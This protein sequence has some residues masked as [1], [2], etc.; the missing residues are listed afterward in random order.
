MSDF[1]A[2]VAND[3]DYSGDVLGNHGLGEH[4]EIGELL[5]EMAQS[6]GL[7]VGGTSIKVYKSTPGHHLIEA[8]NTDRQ[9]S[10]E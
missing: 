10:Y 5:L 7:V 1:S 9:L 3:G 8:Q 2:N 6:F 4:N